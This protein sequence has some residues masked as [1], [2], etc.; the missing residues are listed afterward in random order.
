MSEFK[1]DDDGLLQEETH[2]S[3]LERVQSAGLSTI[4]PE[5]FEK[6]YLNPRRL[7]RETFVA[8]SAIQHP[9]EIRAC[10]IGPEKSI[11]NTFSGWVDFVVALVPLSCTLM[12]WRE[13]NIG[14]NSGPA[15]IYAVHVPL[16]CR[17]YFN[18]L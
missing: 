16:L 2:E 13:T 4:S 17:S 5:M 14:P 3:V 8:H 15:N 9:C 10:P 6:L 11:G 18:S 1:E 12:D 7:S